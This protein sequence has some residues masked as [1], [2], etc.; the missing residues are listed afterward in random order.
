MSNTSTGQESK[1]PRQPIKASNEE[2]KNLVGN[3]KTRLKVYMEEL[4]N[5]RESSTE[6]KRSLNALLCKLEKTTNIPVLR[7]VLGH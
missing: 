4:I 7:E 3:L 1:P 6:D 2:T 5:S